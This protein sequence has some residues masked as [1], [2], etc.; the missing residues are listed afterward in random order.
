MKQY[1]IFKRRA[2]IGFYKSIQPKDIR[3]IYVFIKR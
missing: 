2:G 3:S 1:T